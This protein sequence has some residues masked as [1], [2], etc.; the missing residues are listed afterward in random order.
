MRLKTKNIVLIFVA[1]L[2]LCSAQRVCAQIDAQLTHYWKAPA[3]YNAGAIGNVDFIHITAG[4]RLQWL[5]VEHA[6]MTVL[7]MADMPF[8]FLERRWGGGI[9][10]QQETMGLYR[11][12]NVGAQLAWKKKLFKGELSVGLQVG[13]LNQTFKGTDIFIPEGDDA[14]TSADDAIPNTDVTGNAFDISAGIY[15]THKWF[16]LGIS[17]THL[18][19]PTVTLK[20]NETSEDEYEFKNGRMYYFMAGS[21]IPV[22][23]SLFEIQPSVFVKTDFQF[24]QAEATLRMRYN[25]FITAGVGY[26]WND[27]VMAMIGAEF[28]NFYIG[29]AFDYPISKMSKATM[30]SHEIFLGYNVKLDMKE[31]NRN[32]QKG[33]RIM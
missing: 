27:A 22:K 20:A 10:L 30:G 29:Y 13:F 12:L 15:Y 2:A 5:G 33:V 4:S 1:A 7:G 3:Y 25:K 23:N 8:K 19:E 9:V 11:S 31:R 32:K 21:N 16:W 24:Y 28:K 14:H 18:L 6:P 26:R 17:S